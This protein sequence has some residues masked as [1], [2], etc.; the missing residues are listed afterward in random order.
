MDVDVDVDVDELVAAATVAEVTVA[1]VTVVEEAAGFYEGSQSRRRRSQPATYKRRHIPPASAVEA[2][3]EYN[4]SCHPY[5]A[6]SGK[7]PAHRRS[8]CRSK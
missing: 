2:Y 1:E 4:F 6:T 8:S 5:P 7:S 3:K